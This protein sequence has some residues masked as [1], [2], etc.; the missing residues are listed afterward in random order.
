MVSSGSSRHAALF[1]ALRWVALSS[2]VPDA[3]GCVAVTVMSP[4]LDA[5]SRTLSQ[6]VARKA[7]KPP[8]FAAIGPASAQRRQSGEEA[9]D[10]HLR[11]AA[12]DTQAEWRSW[13]VGRA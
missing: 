12:G 13:P 10:P 11:S 6:R 7:A 2:P 1:S 5:R 4:S 9:V 3:A 8:R